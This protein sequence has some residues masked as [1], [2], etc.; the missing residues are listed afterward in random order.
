MPRPK[1]GDN[2][3]GR[4]QG[5]S[6]LPAH[7]DLRLRRS[8]AIVPQSGHNRT[9]QSFGVSS[10]RDELIPDA[11][12]AG[13]EAAPAL[14]GFLAGADLVVVEHIFFPDADRGEVGHDHVGP[15]Q[16]ALLP[17]QGVQGPQGCGGGQEEAPIPLM[18]I[19]DKDWCRVL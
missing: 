7:D 4:P 2:R 19:Y 17:A 10:V 15:C 11:R 6:D 8:G 5:D 9:L 3:T 18:A 1:G 12:H 13:R 16:D 14:G